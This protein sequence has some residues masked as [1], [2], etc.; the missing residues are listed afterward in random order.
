MIFEHFFR[1]SV[2]K[3]QVSLKSDKTNVYYFFL[4][5]SRSLFLRMRNVSEKSCRENQKTHFMF[6]NVFFFFE[7]RAVYEIMCENIVQPDR[8]LMAIRHMRIACW[9][10]KATDTH[11]EYVIHFAFPLQRWLHE[12]S[13]ICYTPIEQPCSVSPLTMSLS[14]P[15]TLFLNIC[16]PSSDS[17]LT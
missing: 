4:I 6:S 2:E 17:D 10:P 9:I 15:H 12:R 3:I 7:N 13:V 5:I 8:S 1:K 11:P 14:K 16:T